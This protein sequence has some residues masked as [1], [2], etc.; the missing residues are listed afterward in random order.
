MNGRA[1]AGS[2]AFLLLLSVFIKYISG[3]FVLY[4]VNSRRLCY[5]TRMK[6]K[7]YDYSFDVKKQRR[8]TIVSVILFFLIVFA[9]VSLVRSF[10]LFTVRSR[11]VSMQPDIP[12]DSCTVF[13][14]IVKNLLRGDVVMLKSRRTSSPSAFVTAADAVVRFFTAQQYSLCGNDTASEQPEIRRVVALPGDT[15]YMKGYV[16]FVR[17]AGDSHFLT[18]FERA[19]KSYN[20]RIVSVPSDWDSEIGVSGSFEARTLGSGEYFVLGDN[21]TSALDSRLWGAVRLDDIKAKGLAVYFP[22]AKFRLL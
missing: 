18:E 10:A 19:E 16:V 5:V 22:F 8:R 12:S 1:A 4:I 17:P 13:T 21:R 9:G 7:L 11:S 14:P 15:V 2:A 3:T 6:Q 20:V